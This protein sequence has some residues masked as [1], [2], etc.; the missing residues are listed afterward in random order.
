MDL[1]KPIYAIDTETFYSN[2]CNVVDLGPYAYCQHPDW[3]CYLVSISG[4]DGFRWVG[5]PE[6]ADWLRVAGTTWIMANAA[7]DITVIA[8]LKELGIAPS[9]CNPT[10]VFDVLDLARYLQLPGNLAQAGKAIL[11]KVRTNK[12]VRTQMKNKLPKDLTEEK[13]KALFDYALEDTDDT[14]AIWLEAGD[15]WPQWERD[16]SRINRD[17]CEKGLPVDKEQLDRDF[18]HL[19]TLLFNT[20]AQI[21]WTDSETV[22]S[23]KAVARYC[24]DNGILPPISMAKDSI[25]FEQWLAKYGD[26]FP[27]VKAMSEYRRINTLFSRVCAMRR[28]YRTDGTIPIGIKYCG[29]TATRRFSGEGGINFHNMSRDEQYGIDIRKRIVAPKG[30]LWAVVD[31]TS[32]EPAVGSVLCKDVELQEFLRNKGDVYEKCGRDLELYMDPRP[33][34]IGDKPLRQKMKP[35]RLGG[36]YGQGADGL[37]VYAKTAF[38]VDMDRDEAQTLI[39]KFRAKSPKIV[40]QWRKLDMALKSAAGRGDLELRLPSGNLLTYRDVRY[41][42]IKGKTELIANVVKGSMPIEQRLWGSRLH[43]NCC[44]AAARDVLCQY[45]LDLEQDGYDMRLTVHDETVTLVREETAEEDLKHI[46]AVMSSSPKW[47]P[48]LPA[49][50]EGFLCKEYRKG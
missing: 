20:Q 29:A 44:Q 16:L 25:D 32:I 9:D 35:V 18:Q 39:T 8:R 43:E 21:P 50:A 45:I 28:R 6:E 33:I 7:F 26:R 30:F 37:V 4:S 15:K 31:T 2:E 19:N 24:R 41:K 36:E 48:N 10:E 40:A 23:R 49:G 11:K 14:L 3:S 12:N 27:A 5:P 34:K 47:M 13:R 17:M 42:T 38:G 1:E 22:L 46:L